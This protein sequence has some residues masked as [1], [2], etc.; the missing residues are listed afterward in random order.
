M[1]EGIKEYTEMKFVKGSF[2]LIT[3]RILEN[4]IK[5]KIQTNESGQLPVEAS[6]SSAY[7]IP[8]GCK[9]RL[10]FEHTYL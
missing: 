8:P 5:I 9:M 3:K 6:R 2:L 7:A 1:L 10:M 4:G